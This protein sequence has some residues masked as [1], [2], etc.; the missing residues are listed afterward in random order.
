MK[1]YKLFSWVTAAVLLTSCIAQEKPNQLQVDSNRPTPSPKT[2]TLD[3]NYQ[4]VMGQTVYVPV[5]SHVFHQDEKNIFDLAATLS[6]RNT[7]FKEAIAIASVKY[8]DW[9]GKL[10]KNYLEQPIEIAALSSTDFFINT[11]DRSGGSGAKFIVEWV[12]QTN[13]SEPIVEAIMI[14]TGFQQ[15]I[16]FVSPGKVIENH[17]NSQPEN[18]N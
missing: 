3:E 15:G 13:V 11:S 4:K 7:D 6:I 1:L 10:V 12:A 14:G 9:N 5:Y 18:P 16:S 17:H 8:Y 2:I